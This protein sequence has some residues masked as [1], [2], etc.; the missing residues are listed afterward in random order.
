MSFVLVAGKKGSFVSFRFNKKNIAFPPEV[1]LQPLE[2]IFS[3]A[4]TQK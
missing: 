1:N 3:N 2:Y 4:F